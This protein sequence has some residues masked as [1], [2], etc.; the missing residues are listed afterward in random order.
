MEVICGLKNKT[1][2]GE[3]GIPI[4]LLKTV[5]H[6]IAAPLSHIINLMFFTGVYPELL[7]TGQVRAVYKK[8]DKS[9]IGNYRPITLL[10]TPSKVFEKVILNRLVTFLEGNSLLS[11]CQSGFREKKT[12]TRAI[13][14]ALEAILCS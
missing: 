6:L 12:T 14:Q 2:V 8:R 10:P 4:I 9:L 11:E 7:K 13:Y 1:S 3:D 5:S